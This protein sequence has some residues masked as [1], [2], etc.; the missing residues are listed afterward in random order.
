MAGARHLQSG[1]AS[2]PEPPHGVML[3]GAR[4]RP[5]DSCGVEAPLSLQDHACEART[6][7]FGLHSGKSQR[8]PLCGDHQRPVVPRQPA[9]RAHV[10]RV[11]ADYDVDRLL[12]YETYGEVLTAIR[13][14][15]QLKNW[16]REKKIAL[17]EKT[18]PQWKDLSREWYEAPVRMTFQG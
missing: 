2:L 6:P 4:V 5:A 7:L 11:T 12:Y 16:R 9:Q 15:K 13:R 1:Y 8:Y 3:S 14:E 17:I 10:S 18:N